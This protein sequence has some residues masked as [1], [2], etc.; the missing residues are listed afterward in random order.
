MPSLRRQ[1]SD[2]ED[3]IVHAVEGGVMD[4]QKAVPNNCHVKTPSGIYTGS[5]KEL[6]R[7]E[8]FGD[9]LKCTLID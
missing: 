2:Y 1:K 3:R 7:R 5:V 4:Y 9:T 6:L 8:C